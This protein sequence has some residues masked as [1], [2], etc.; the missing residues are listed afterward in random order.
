MGSAWRALA[1]GFAGLRPIGNAL[2][3]DPVLAPG[4]DALELR[5]RFRGSRV[6]SGWIPS[7]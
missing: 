6:R 2:G 7:R 1:F 4:W 5:V 3:I